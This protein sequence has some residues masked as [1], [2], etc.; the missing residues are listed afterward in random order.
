MKILLAADGSPFTQKALEFIVTHQ[1]LSGA[2]DELSVVNVQAPV[3]GR[4][5][6]MLRPSE[7]AAYHSEESSKV[8]TPIKAFL[9]QHGIR[10]HCTAVVGAVVEEIIGAAKKDQAQLIVMGT[11][12]HGWLGRA[13]LGSTTQRVIVDSPVAVLLVK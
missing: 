2:D 4:V 7:V 6:T 13:L 8:L 3:P 11:H 10:H 9:E 5:S 1:S 12:G